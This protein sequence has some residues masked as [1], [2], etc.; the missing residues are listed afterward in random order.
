MRK[1][2]LKLAQRISS[3]RCKNREVRV[4]QKRQTAKSLRRMT[5]ACVSGNESQ[6]S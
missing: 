4:R 1:W 5:L 6:Q 3:S 2:H